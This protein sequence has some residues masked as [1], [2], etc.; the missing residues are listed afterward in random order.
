M[1]TVAIIQARMSSKRLPGKVMLPFGDGTVL[2]SVITRLQK[3]KR[4]D[5]IIVVCPYGDKEIIREAIDYGVQYW[6]GPEED[7]LERYYKCAKFY[8]ID[9]IIRITADCPYI[10]P[11]LVDDTIRNSRHVNYGS[12]VLTRTYPKGLDCE[13][14]SFDELD[15]AYQFAKGEEREHVTPY[16]IKH[17]MSKKCLTNKENYSHKR[18]TLDYDYDYEDLKK[19]YPIIGKIYDYP[20]LK[21]KLNELQSTEEWSIK[22]EL[23]RV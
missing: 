5:S 10:M 21:T 6:T 23:G 20:T 15:R 4:L 11:D 18:L 7:V 2:S 14:F 12:N 19:Y 22:Q 3:C 8:G 17:V 13:V 16:I 1:K 9:R